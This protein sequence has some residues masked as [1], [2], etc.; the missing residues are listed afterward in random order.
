M[1]GK[2]SLLQSIKDR[3]EK[4]I[5]VC[6]TKK[7]SLADVMEWH[8]RRA[9]H[10]ESSVLRFADSPQFAHGE[11]LELWQSSLQND[12]EVVRSRIIY[13]LS[14]EEELDNLLRE[15]KGVYQILN[16]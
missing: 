5:E 13:A 14:V 7:L 4:E 10:L 6:Y 12:N 1:F 15:G 9:A 8:R 3:C 11:C 2:K 16:H